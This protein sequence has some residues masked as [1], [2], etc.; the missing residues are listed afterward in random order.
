MFGLFKNRKR[1]NG[2]VDTKLNNEYQ[3]VT[4]D[5]PLFPGML[6]YLELIDQAWNGR[7]NESEAAMYIA[8]LYHSGIKKHGDAAEASALAGRIKAVA[9]FNVQTGQI[10]AEKARKFIGVVETGVIP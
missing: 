3:I 5:N 9:Q 10:S 1:Y 8:V 4:R 2:D 7:M 6:A